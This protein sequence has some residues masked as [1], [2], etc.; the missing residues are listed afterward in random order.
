MFLFVAD[1]MLKITL[2]H[3]LQSRH[4]NI[5]GI[6]K[7]AFQII[8]NGCKA[9]SCNLINMRAAL[10]ICTNVYVSL[11][12][13]ILKK[14]EFSLFDI[15][16]A[17]KLSYNQRKGFRILYETEFD[18]EDKQM[19]QMLFTLAIDLQISEL[20]IVEAL[21][22]VEEACKILPVSLKME[23]WTKKAQILELSGAGA[24]SIQTTIQVKLNQEQ[25]LKFLLGVAKSLVGVHA[26][27]NMLTQIMNLAPSVTPEMLMEASF[28]G[29]KIEK[30]SSG[31][32]EDLQKIEWR[33]GKDPMSL[34]LAL[35]L[36]HEIGG[37]EIYLLA[38]QIIDELVHQLFA[39]L[40]DGEEFIEESA[41]ALSLETAQKNVAVKGKKMG[42]KEQVLT[43]PP[44]NSSIPTSQEW[45][46]FKWPANFHYKVSRSKSRLFLNTSTIT[47]SWHVLKTLL[48]TLKTYLKS[49][50]YP[51][52]FPILSIMGLISDPIIPQ[53]LFKVIHEFLSTET[54]SSI[55]ISKMPYS[56]EKLG[57]IDLSHNPIAN[58]VYI[59]LLSIELECY[60]KIMDFLSAKKISYQILRLTSTKSDKSQKA[61]SRALSTLALIYASSGE[62]ENGFKFALQATQIDADLGYFSAVSWRTR[63]FCHVQKSTPEI[64][65]FELAQTLDFINIVVGKQTHIQETFGRSGCSLLEQLRFDIMLYLNE[66]KHSQI[67]TGFQ[68]CLGKMPIILSKDIEARGASIKKYLNVLIER[69]DRSPIK[70][71][72]I[73]EHVRFLDMI[74]STE[75]NQNLIADIWF[76]KAIFACELYLC[77]MHIVK[78]RGDIIKEYLESLDRYGD[79]P[80][81][82]PV[83]ISKLLTDA[84]SFFELASV[85]DWRHSYLTGCEYFINWKRASEDLD[86]EN[87]KKELREKSKAAF[88]SCFQE[89]IILGNIHLLS[90]LSDCMINLA[91]DDS[92]EAFKFVSLLQSCSV[93]HV[94]KDTRDKLLQSKTENIPLWTHAQYHDVLVARLSLE[95]VNTT[96]IQSLKYATP[97]IPSMTVLQTV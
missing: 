86:S 96:T 87:T 24:M 93:N 92:K 95:P 30:Y 12:P 18:D 45:H 66:L 69:N 26:Q 67:N 42:K 71:N 20:K 83:D 39:G 94:L 81:E 49:G 22:V 37:P 27:I 16:N 1:G 10:R 7:Y 32:Y 28:R 88:N 47:N 4:T 72:E 11:P 82:T 19:I 6:L 91:V 56:E 64:C 97:S 74:A 50:E 65:I 13:A 5:C 90:I 46:L 40:N 53:I 48:R 14:H 44:K 77:N 54:G 57:V 61:T 79:G 35:D 9:D 17:L 29:I 85:K 89:I 21:Q 41:L 75:L 55:T 60:T 33:T 34:I 52:C 25:Q 80:H 3:K 15:L 43:P 70:T 68:N 2:D 8:E 51:K 38:S 36:V 23:I 84:I 59:D 63:V 76:A 31:M 58:Q 78:K 73:A 62:F